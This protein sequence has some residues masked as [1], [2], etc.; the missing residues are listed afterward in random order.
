MSFPA[1]L[2]MSEHE[3]EML[4]GGNAAALGVKA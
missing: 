3:R 4:Y 2:N 1:D